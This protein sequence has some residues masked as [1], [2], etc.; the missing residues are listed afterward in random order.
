MVLIRRCSL[1]ILA[2]RRRQMCHWAPPVAPAEQPT[3]S[4]TC[5]PSADATALRLRWRG[6]CT[7]QSLP[8]ISFTFTGSTTFRASRQ[9][10]LRSHPACRTSFSRTAAST[11]ICA[12][13]TSSSSRFTWRPSAGRSCVRQP[14]SCSTRPRKAN[15]QPTPR[16][17]PNGRCRR[18]SP[19]RTSIRCRPEAR[20]AAAFPAVTGPF[21]LFVGRLSAAKGARPPARRL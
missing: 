1:R 17:V 18:A 10:G 9:R 6:R 2:P 12:R 15:S 4:T 20:S 8:T 19:V 5:G 14:L 21:L 13:R 7:A 3:T 11:R 16:D